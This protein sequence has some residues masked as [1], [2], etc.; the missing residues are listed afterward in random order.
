MEHLMVS[1]FAILALA[2]P[3]GPAGAASPKPAATPAPGIYLEPGRDDAGGT[4]EKLEA[5]S[6]TRVGTKDLKKGI[7]TS[8]LTGGLLGGGPK[9]AYA[10]AGA[11]ARRRVPSGS[12]FQFH[13]D[14]TAAAAPTAP[15]MPSDP[16]SM[17]AMMQQ[18]AEAQAGVADSGMPASARQPQDFVLV[19]LGGKGEERE[20]VVGM[21]AKA[22]NTLPCRTRQLG[23][24]VFRVAPEKPLPPGEYG[25][26]AVSKNGPGA[27]S[28]RLWDFGVDPN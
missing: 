28:N 17:M 5:S 13:F 24:G 22:K 9:L 27:G 26:Y 8:M 23:P 20:L 25:F 15:A 2:S 18:Q 10:Y 16:A 4:L 12:W 7:A 19:R 1:V 21:D 11:H 14:P 6:T 3:P